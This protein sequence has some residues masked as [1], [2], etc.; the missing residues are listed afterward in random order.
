MVLEKR[1]LI[2]L[3]PTEALNPTGSEL[4]LNEVAVMM[5]K[6]WT[7]HLIGS[8]ETRYENLRCNYQVHKVRMVSGPNSIL[9]RAFYLIF[10]IYKGAKLVKK[11]KIHVILAKE[12]HLVH[13]LVSLAIKKLTGTRCVVR[14]NENSV[15]ELLLFV[16][17]LETPLL[18]TTA[19][20]RIFETLSRKMETYVFKHADWIMTQG[21]MDFQRIKKITENVSFVPLWVD[22]QKFR[23]FANIQKSQR[24]A[25]LQ[26]EDETKVLL[27]VGRL[28]LEKDI[29]TLLY[30]FKKLQET[31]IDTILV[32]IG[33]GPEEERSKELARKLGIL[34][35]VKF[36]G[37]ISHDKLPE[38]YNVADVYVLTSIWE[39]W[40]NTIMEAMA[41]GLPVIATNV[42]G[43]PY[44]V[45]DGVTGFLVP[46]KD[47]LALAEK[48][49]YVLNH[50]EEAKKISLKASLEIEKYNKEYAGELYKTII[51]QVISRKQKYPLRDMS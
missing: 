37:Y 16:K 48:M 28:H 41:C 1:L 35:K 10:S 31:R 44:L 38:Y 30:A 20:L 11:H 25:L 22:T 51:N 42:G 32:M 9:S 21:P 46:P 17:R 40:S 50:L 19:S 47:L 45:K 27:F 43:N 26:V 5:D 34:N 4:K 29:D 8:Q 39:E 12:G 2:I 24:K 13:G 33:T 14:V 36:L 3:D 15:L 49:A 18:S 6:Q 23:P 7:L